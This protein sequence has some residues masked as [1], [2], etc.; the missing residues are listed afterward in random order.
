MVV[1][2]KYRNKRAALRR[3]QAWKWF[4]TFRNNNID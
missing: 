3:E 2:L 4:N 1:R